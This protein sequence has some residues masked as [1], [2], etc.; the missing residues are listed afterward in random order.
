KYHPGYSDSAIM[1]TYASEIC[2][3]NNQLTQDLAETRLRFSPITY[4]SKVYLAANERKPLDEIRE[5]ELLKIL[6]HEALHSVE[7]P[8]FTELLNTHIPP[9][10]QGDIKE[11]I[12]DYLAGQIWGDVLSKAQDPGR[13]RKRTTPSDEDFKK[14]LQKPFGIIKVEEK[15]I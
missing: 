11:G 13:A 9:G 14:P 10:L 1:E 7:H 5:W 2:R 12:V 3:D 15:R 8:N 6:V 4:G